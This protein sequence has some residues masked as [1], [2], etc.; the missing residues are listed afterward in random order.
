M[1]TAVIGQVRLQL[2]VLVVADNCVETQILY[3]SLYR[4]VY[5]AVSYTHL[6]VYKRQEQAVACVC[7]VVKV[8]MKKL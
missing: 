7:R 8:M 1:S 2:C 6:D 5:A 3:W 4:T